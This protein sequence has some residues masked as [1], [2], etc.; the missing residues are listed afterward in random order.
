MTTRFPSPTPMILTAL[1]LSTLA[2]PAAA[3]CESGHDALRQ[4]MSRQ[5][6]VIRSCRIARPA[7]RTAPAVPAPAPPV[8]SATPATAPAALAAVASS[9]APATPAPSAAPSAAAQR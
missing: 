4:R 5:R 1:V 9:S 7:A 6:A 2:G 3:A 8:A